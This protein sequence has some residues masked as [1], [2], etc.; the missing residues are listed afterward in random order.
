MNKFNQSTPSVPPPT[1]PGYSDRQFL[2]TLLAGALLP[3]VQSTITAIMAG[4]GT[5]TILYLFDAIDYW[6]PTLIVSAVVWVVAW[7][8]TQR[9]WFNLTS[10]ENIIGIDIN[11]DGEIGKPTKE[12]ELVIRLDEI[13]AD[14]HYRSRKINL[15]ISDE[16][17]TTLARG[18]LTGIPFSERRWAGQG[19][20]LSSPQFRALRSE[21]LKQGLL[22]VMNDKDN[23]QGFDFNAQGW[24]FLEKVA[25]Y[26]VD[27]T[28]EDV[29]EAT[30]IDD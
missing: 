21:F 14:N 26:E 11:G 12:P 25:G 1:Q 8:Y 19:K 13:T 23:R 17:L 10:F 22:E 6:K 5:I 16:T 29:E 2:H 24:A 4:I 20:L 3:F 28:E 27:S 7:I 30:I 18:L 15:A 9:R